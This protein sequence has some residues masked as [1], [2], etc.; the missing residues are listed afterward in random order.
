VDASGTYRTMKREFV[1]GD[2]YICIDDE[3]TH[4]KSFIG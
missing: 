4:V 3:F 2:A 1:P